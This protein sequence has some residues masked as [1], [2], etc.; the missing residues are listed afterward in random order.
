M[1]TVHSGEDKFIPGMQGGSFMEDHTPFIRIRDKCPP[2]AQQ[3]R[4]M[5]LKYT[6]LS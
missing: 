2:S 4:K 1:R 5:N 3:T 6:I